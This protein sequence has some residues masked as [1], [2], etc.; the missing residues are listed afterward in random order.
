MSDSVTTAS[1]Y[2]NALNQSMTA[3]QTIQ[4]A[5]LNAQQTQASMAAEE[6]KSQWNVWKI[7][8]DTQNKV[9][10]IQQTVTVDK[11]KTQDKMFNKWDEAIKAQFNRINKREP[12]EEVLFY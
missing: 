1:N 2:A 8:Q 9:Y 4:T 10:E 5:Q 3:Q 11:A 12:L 6:T 7:Q